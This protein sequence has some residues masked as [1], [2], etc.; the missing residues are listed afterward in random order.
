MTLLETRLAFLTI[1]NNLMRCLGRLQNHYRNLSRA[2]NHFVPCMRHAQ[3]Q[4]HTLTE[5]SLTIAALET[6]EA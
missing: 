5:A 6:R 3:A 1:R 2:A 4:T